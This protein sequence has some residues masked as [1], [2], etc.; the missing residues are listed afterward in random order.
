MLFSKKIQFPFEEGVLTQRKIKMHNIKL[1]TKLVVGANQFAFV[2]VKKKYYD[3]FFEGEFELSGGYIPKTFNALGLHKPIKSRFTKKTKFAKSFY[4][5]VI[6]VNLQ[7]Y[8]QIDFATPSF[9]IFDT[10][11]D[12]RLRVNGKF[13]FEIVDKEL[14]SK[15]VA[16]Y[17]HGN[18]YLIKKISKV[19]SKKIRYE[20]HKENIP[21]LDFLRKDSYNL[22][23]LIRNKLSKRLVKI[24]IYVDEVILEE[25]KLS[26]HSQVCVKELIESGKIFFQY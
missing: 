19:V 18:D 9:L 23:E 21:I 24:G 4:G 2:C 6:F 20:W 11:C 10:E 7:K 3:K 13:S 14:F 22:F 17:K 8:E 16:K 12:A 15:F 25:V 5:C 1:G 26:K